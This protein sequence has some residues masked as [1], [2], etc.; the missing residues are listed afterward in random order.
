GLLFFV[1]VAVALS[2]RCRRVPEQPTDKAALRVWRRRAW[3]SMANATF[4]AALF[5]YV[6]YFV[7]SWHEP[8]DSFNIIPHFPA[9]PLLRRLLMPL[10]ENLRGLLWVGFHAAGRGAP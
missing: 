1:F 9:S 7:L 10:W 6:A 2:L 3:R 4:W 5:V 8:T